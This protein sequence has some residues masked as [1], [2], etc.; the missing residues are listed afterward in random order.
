MN[1]HEF[2]NDGDAGLAPRSPEVKQ[3]VFVAERDVL[4]LDVLGGNGR[5]AEALVGHDGCGR[6][7]EWR[8][9][10]MAL[11]A[12]EIDVEE[13]ENQ[14]VEDDGELDFAQNTVLQQESRQFVAVRGDGVGDGELI[15]VVGRAYMIGLALVAEIANEEIVDAEHWDEFVERQRAGHCS[16]VSGD[17][18]QADSGCK[19]DVGVP[20]GNKVSFIFYLLS[21]EIIMVVIR[22]V[23]VVVQVKRAEVGI[24]LL[25]VAG[26]DANDAALLV[27]AKRSRVGGKTFEFGFR[28]LAFV[29]KYVCADDVLHFQFHTDGDCL[30]ILPYCSESC[31]NY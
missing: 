3:R 17:T 14:T 29:H 12:A 18:V 4:A 20:L 28:R 30:C 6:V 23:A 19:P 27:E 25:A 26:E 16:A 15:L 8:D 13:S 22:E 2:G 31:E 10:D 7:V 21:R 5:G 9:A 1:I 24:L 11:L